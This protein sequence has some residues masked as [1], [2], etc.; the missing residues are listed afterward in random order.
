MG[1][2]SRWVAVVSLAAGAS[3]AALPA[4]TAAFS[5]F[6]P[7]SADAVYGGDLTFIVEL[8]G[9][10]PE[11]LELLLRFGDAEETFVTSV[12]ADGARASFA[13]DT[14]QQHVTPNTEVHYRWRAYDGAEVALSPERSVLH[15]DDRPGLDWHSER[16]G[17]ATVHW[18]GGAEA[19][20]RRFGDLSAQGA[21]RA[22]DLLGHQLAGPIDI[23]VYDA[24]DAFFGALG[25]GAR[26]WTG[27]ATFPALRTIF[28]WLRGGPADYLDTA[29]VHE[30]THVVF[31]DA[32]DNPFHA[33]AT[34]LNEG[35][36]TWSE[37]ESAAAER[38]TVEFE[39][40]GGG[41]FAFDAI[42]D[43][44][45]IGSRGSSLSYAQGATMV[46]MIIDAH[47]RDA[48]AAMAAAY[49]DGAS[50]AEALEE[51]TGQPADELYA[52]FYAAFGVDPPQPVEPALILPSDVDKP[53]QPAPGEEE[54]ASPAPSAA[55]DGDPAAGDVQLLILGIV[56]VLVIGTVAGLWYAA[57]RNR[58]RVIDA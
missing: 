38:A 7:T 29:I 52:D 4:P 53:G 12:A 3:L 39:A 55:A 49:R 36:A 43:Q 48:M 37:A 31:H 58:A 24:Q 11:R 14:A 57:R 40:S 2:L 35:V 34:W 10:P 9:G 8:P 6:G 5:G 27:A 17:D 20:A 33:P 28:M 30:A 13:W 45:P 25:P 46:E 51:G 44:F 56:G 19:Q 1:R 22:E 23:F 41:L 18:Y 16:I 50:D 15:D 54:P 26:E 47:G 21:R 42:T 32:T